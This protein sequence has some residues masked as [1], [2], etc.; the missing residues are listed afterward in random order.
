MTQTFILQNQNNHFFGKNK[1]W[2]D[3]YDPNSLF[4]SLHKDEAINQ[5]VEISSKDYQQRVRIIACDIDEKG[6]PIIDVA[7]MPAPLPKPPKPAKNSDIPDAIIDLFV[8][9]TLVIEDDDGPLEAIDSDEDLSSEPN[10]KP[11][12]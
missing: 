4:K 5:M 8:A 1:E 11:T 10:S 12:L 3:G 7:I 2:Q 9:D 6:L